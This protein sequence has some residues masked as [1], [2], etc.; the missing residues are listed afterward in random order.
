MKLKE[1]IRKLFAKQSSDEQAETEVSKTEEH[2][3]QLQFA[4]FMLRSGDYSWDVHPFKK[5]TLVNVEQCKNRITVT[6]LA[7]LWHGTGHIEWEFL[8]GLWLTHDIVE[9]IEAGEKETDISRLFDKEFSCRT[10]KLSREE[11]HKIILPN[12]EI[13]SDSET[14]MRIALKLENLTA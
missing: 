6:G 8:L 13:I 11:V 10:R 9:A 2:D 5:V 12:F 14:E 7:S 1:R 3:Y 4:D